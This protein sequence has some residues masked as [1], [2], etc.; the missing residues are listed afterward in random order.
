MKFIRQLFCKHHE[1]IKAGPTFNANHHIR[2]TRVKCT[3]C[4]NANQHIR[5]TRVKCTCCDKEF[6]VDVQSD[7]YIQGLK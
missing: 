1:F 4:D 2:M 6:F 3:C 5:M 7:R